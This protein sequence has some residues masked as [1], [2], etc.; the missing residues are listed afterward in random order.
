MPDASAR[1]GSA[2]VGAE[3]QPH[4]DVVPVVAGPDPD[5]PGHPADLPVA[6]A[7]VEGLQA[8]AAAQGEPEPGEA[9][10]AGGALGLG[11]Q[12]GAVAAALQPGVDH[13]PLE[14]PPV[15]H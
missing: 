8:V 13:D 11:E 10:G 9:L 2:D 3:V 14:N 5:R 1:T 15:V 6:G 4:G 7:A 12:V